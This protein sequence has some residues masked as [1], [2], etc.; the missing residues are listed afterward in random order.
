[1][2]YRAVI[3]GLGSTACVSVALVTLTVLSCTPVLEPPRAPPGKPYV[4]ACLGIWRLIA[5]H[6][7]I[8]LGAPLSAD[9]QGSNLR[10]F[11]LFSEDPGSAISSCEVH[12]DG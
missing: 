9:T 1:M 6:Q 2:H 7:G 3:P 4:A 8:S 5:D 12:A 10:H 11:Q